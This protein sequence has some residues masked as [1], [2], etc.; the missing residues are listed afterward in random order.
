[1]SYKPKYENVKPIYMF[2]STGA[3]TNSREAKEQVRF[4]STSEYRLYLQLLELFPST[5]FNVEHH[6]SLSWAEERWKLDFRVSARHGCT[7]SQGKLAYIANSIN[8]T[9]YEMLTQLYIEYKGVQDDNFQRKM[10]HLLDK[11]PMLSGTI[12]LVSSETTAFG[13]YSE[14]QGRIL[15]H[16]I[17]SVGV[18]NHVV[19]RYKSGEKD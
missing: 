17:A 9:C 16:P 1:V 7:S 18:L 10:G 12:I 15:T 5:K 11:M 4:D 13:A 3:I 2:P 19:K 14:K 6:V 8:G